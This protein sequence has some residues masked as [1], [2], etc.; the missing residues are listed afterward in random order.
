MGVKM[1]QRLCTTLN[2][3]GKLIPREDNIYKH[4]KN[5]N[6][7]YYSSIYYYTTEHKE[8]AEED[9]EGVK[10]GKTFKRKRGISGITDIVTDRLVFD[11]DSE[12]DVSLAQQ[13]TQTLCDRLFEHGIEGGDI[14]V[15]FS[16]NKG[17]SVTVYHNTEMGPKEAK[18]IAIT[19]AGDLKTFDSKVYNASR[20]FR[21]NHTKHAK[22][23]LYKTPIGMDEL[24][25]LSMDEIKVL[26]KEQ[27][28]PE[29]IVRTNLPQA[30]IDMQI[31]PEKPEDVPKSVLPQ[32]LDI[33]YKDKPKWLSH[34]KYA[35]LN[36]YF[37]LGTRSYALMVL[38]ATYKNQGQPKEITY[39]MLKGAATLQQQRY[40]GEKFDKDRIWN[41]VIEQI[42]SD[43]WKGGMYAEDNFP[44]D[45]KQY[46]DDL[47]VPRQE[48]AETENMFSTP[49]Q[50]FDIFQNFAENIDKN[51]I[52]TGIVPLD[53][54]EDLRLTTSMLVGILGA[55]GSGKTSV[56]LNMLNKVSDNGEDC[57]F[58]SMDMGAP[59]VFQRLAQK[60]TN[61]TDKKI[62]ELFQNK[63]TK[64]IDRIRKLICKR[65]KNTHFSFKTA[66][67]TKMIRQG[68]INMQEKSDKK[69][70]VAVIDYLECI[71]GDISDPTAK[72]SMISQELKDI[73]SDLEVCVVLLL[74]PPKRVGD[75]SKEILSYTDIKGAATVAQACS[76][77][78]SLW[79]E[80]FNPKETDRDNYLSFAIIKNRM[81]KLAQIDCGWK[82][83]TGEIYELEDIER[84]ELKE[85]RMMLS[86]NKT[87]DDF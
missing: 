37:P 55:P 25:D 47:G 44:D 57:A 51:T 79:R 84:M 38:G 54:S 29:D 4:I 65:Y 52:Q 6:K 60:V 86:E 82:G 69:I 59:L 80:G 30:I 77:V 81:G 22:T 46:L 16:G 1:Y 19:L 34:W 27:Y 12:S 83:L 70:R 61:Y 53:K 24:Y 10:D 23:G 66:M 76:V 21:L 71:S 40:G 73:A 14:E 39:Q 9:I 78:L 75:P 41:T 42:Y 62:F 48:V 8:S 13:D 31:P 64:E 58:F 20:I 17:F 2:S 85:L 32:E 3:V 74:Q 67:N 7:D 56:I 72:I 87:E 49:D 50:V 28:E 26:A 15:A 68:I 63:D 5:L 35:L 45:L 33:S 36:G 11:F 18:T 43:Q